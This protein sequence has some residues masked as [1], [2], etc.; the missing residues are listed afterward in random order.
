[1][2]D[3]I[4]AEREPL[5]Q[6]ANAVRS[7]TGSTEMYT[8]NELS[9]TITDILQNSTNSRD[10]ILVSPNGTNFKINITNDGIL[11]SEEIV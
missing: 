8:V 2:T 5:A 3:Y 10:L 4:L 1:M 9:E 11:T 6:M 7:T